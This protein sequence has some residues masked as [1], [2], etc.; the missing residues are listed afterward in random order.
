MDTLYESLKFL[1]TTCGI[2]CQVGTHIVV[3]SD[4]VGRPCQTLHYIA[5]VARNTEFG[6][7]SSRSVIYH[8]RE[9]D[10]RTA[11]LFYLL[12]SSVGERTE[13]TATVFG[14]CSIRNIFAPFGREMPD[15]R[16]INNYFTHN[17]A[18]L[19]ES[20]IK[21]WLLGK[22]MVIL[23][24]HFCGQSIRYKHKYSIRYWL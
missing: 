24:P 9:P 3:V 11:E 1:H 15:K 5:T 4:G 12:Q 20:T 17:N 22:K 13:F 7:R 2:I 10:M 21:Y 8:S 16:L 18:I 14:D 23:H 19:C 6:V